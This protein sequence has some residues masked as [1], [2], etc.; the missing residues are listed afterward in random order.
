MKCFMECSNFGFW[1]KPVSSSQFP[2][3]LS[4]P[5]LLWCLE[6]WPHNNLVLSRLRWKNGHLIKNAN[7]KKYILKS[8]NWLAKMS[9]SLFFLFETFLKTLQISTCSGVHT[10]SAD[11]RKLLW[12]GI[13]WANIPWRADTVARSMK[14][15]QWG[16]PA[17]TW[18]ACVRQHNLGVLMGFHL[19]E[20]SPRHE[21]GRVFL[22]TSR[23]NNNKN[24][25]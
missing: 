5:S 14:H 12:G 21:E 9:C 20:S 16:P 10:K 7:E 25:F 17:G 4:A 13:C 24:E 18:N 23:P 11:M 2:G 3:S 19:N 1:G 8:I 6:N 22:S 15:W